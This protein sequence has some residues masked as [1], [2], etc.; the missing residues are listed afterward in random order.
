M[1]KI[2]CEM[3]QDLL[4]SYIDELTSDIT[5]REIEAHMKE[6]ERCKKVLEQM[7]TPD[8][9]SS[10]KERKEIDFLKKTKKNIRE[11]LSFAQLLSGLLPWY[12]SAQ[13]IILEGNT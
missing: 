9:E 1:S 10:E 5:N 11:I 2:T 4:P 3:I 8:M 7:R 13:D 6:C 12:F